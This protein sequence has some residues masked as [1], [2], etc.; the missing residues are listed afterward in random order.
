MVKTTLH[1]IHTEKAGELIDY[2]LTL[3]YYIVSEPFYAEYSDLLRY[4][5]KIKLIAEFEDGTF[6]EESKEIRDIFYR[7]Q[8]AE[9]FVEMLSKNSVTPTH[10]QDIVQDYIQ[11]TLRAAKK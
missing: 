9:K 11:D 8:D 7:K 10:L 4:G 1:S 5:V 2:N 3:K 6:E